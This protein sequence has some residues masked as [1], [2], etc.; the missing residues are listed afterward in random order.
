MQPSDPLHINI[1]SIYSM[2]DTQSHKLVINLKNCTF[3]CFWYFSTISAEFNLSIC[4]RVHIGLTSDQIQENALL[5]ERLPRSYTLEKVRELGVKEK[6]AAA[7]S[8]RGLCGVPESGEILFLYQY[9]ARQEEENNREKSP[10]SVKPSSHAGD[11]EL[12][13]KHRFIV[14]QWNVLTSQL[15][16]F[17]CPGEL[18]DDEKGQMKL[19][20]ENSPDIIL[21]KYLESRVLMLHQQDR[22][23]QVND[24]YHLKEL[25]AQQNRLSVE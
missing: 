1:R 21:E 9:H 24:E 12:Y 25:V 19:I 3:H 7:D 20:N 6:K 14:G 11:S 22:L 4:F 2:I 23:R 13:E 15:E 18:E 16:Q 10:D 5:K 8:A 17:K